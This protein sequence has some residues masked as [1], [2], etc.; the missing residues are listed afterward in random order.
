MGLVLPRVTFLRAVSLLSLSISLVIFY[1]VVYLD[2][3]AL[4]TTS[5]APQVGDNNEAVGPYLHDL[6]SR[7]AWRSNLSL[8]CHSHCGPDNSSFCGGLNNARDRLQTCVRLAIDA[9]ATTVLIPSIA[10][11]SEARLW[12]VD[13]SA[14]AE[15][16]AEGVGKPVMLCP[17]TWFSL[18]RLEQALRKGCDQL[19]VRFICP[20]ANGLVDSLGTPS[21]EI[22]KMSWRQVGGQRFD[23]RPGH[24]FRE[25]V[26]EALLQI[27]GEPGSVLV[28]YGDPYIACMSFLIA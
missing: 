21:P 11:R 4:L 1:R 20:T 13:P 7:T 6:C 26:D 19:R 10:T 14:V 2:E 17:E 24:T 23:I 8:H 25:A 5:A 15:D 3:S 16:E 9:G 28:D 12:V 22:L 27:P 18:S